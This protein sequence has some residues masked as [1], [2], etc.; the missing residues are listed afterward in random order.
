VLGINPES[1]ERLGRGS[2]GDGGIDFCEAEIEDFG[3]AAPRDED[4]G[5]LDVSVDNALGMGGIE[6]VGNVD[7]EV[8]RAVGS[9]GRPVIVLE[10]DA[11]EKPIAM[12]GW[13]L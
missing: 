2:N 13:P 5:G 12:N 6:G 7:G 11:I 10:R 1:G 3:V 8:S 9:I 4:V